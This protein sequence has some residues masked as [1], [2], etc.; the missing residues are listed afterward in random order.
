MVEATY[1]RERDLIMLRDDREAVAIERIGGPDYV[2]WKP[3]P[4]LETRD[5]R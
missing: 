3:E 4:E 5:C 1:E 2:W